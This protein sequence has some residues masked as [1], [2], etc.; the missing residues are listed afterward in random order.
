[1]LN[2]SYEDAVHIIIPVFP[3]HYCICGGLP[4]YQNFSDTYIDFLFLELQVPFSLTQHSEPDSEYQDTVYSDTVDGGVVFNLQVKQAKK[5]QRT[6]KCSLPLK[7][8]EAS[9]CLG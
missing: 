3:K 2:S 4:Q 6:I 7:E 1:M 5:R 9:V 8:L